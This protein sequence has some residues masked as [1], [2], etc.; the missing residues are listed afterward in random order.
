[1][2]ASATER[3]TSG[4]LRAGAALALALLAGPIAGRAAHAQNAPTS[5]LPAAPSVQAATP[6]SGVPSASSAATPASA[7]PGETTVLEQPLSSLDPNAFGILDDSHGGL[8]AGMWSGTDAAL[9]ATLIPNLVPSASRPLEGLMRRLLLSVATPPEGGD[10]VVKHGGDPLLVQRARALW[11]LGD[12]DDL[13]ALLKALPL[14]A[15]TPSLRR[16]RADS[17]LLVGDTGTACAEAAPLAAASATDPYPVELRVYCQFAAG[18][19][20]AAGLGVDILREQGVDDAAFFALAETLSGLGA[21]PKDGIAQ[22]TPLILAMARLAKLEQTS[23]PPAASPIVLRS[24]AQVGGA[25]F[26]MRL[27]AG[28]RAEAVGALDTDIL[29]RLYESVPFTADDLTNAEAKATADPNPRA[30]ARLYQ[31]AER[32]AV[33]L[34]KAGLAA[35]ALG[36]PDGPGY[37]VTARVFAPQIAQ[38][39]PTG[40]IATYVPTLARALLAAHQLEPARNWVGWT[41]AQATSDPAAASAAASFTVLAKLAKLDDAPLT[42]EALDAWRKAGASLPADRAARRAAL[43]IALLSAVGESLPVQAWLPLFDG[44]APVS[45][46]IPPTALALGLDAAASGKRLGE[47]ILFACAAL[48]DGTTTQIDVADLARVVAALRGAGFDDAARQLALEAALANG[49]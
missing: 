39:Q 5:L 16:L 30:R 17:A 37:F 41:R 49:V 38:L 3:R 8:A 14:P 42:P 26:D 47:T 34:A 1:M 45:A 2:T 46:M 15:V 29:R 6:L 44:T 23:V 18:Q 40:D 25:P 20:A 4:A 7:P 9:V 11:T 28:E 35:R 33:P 12:A 19:A 32:Q 27:A 13:A 48:G 21:S 24:I 10:T 36:A 43:G 22:P 31:A